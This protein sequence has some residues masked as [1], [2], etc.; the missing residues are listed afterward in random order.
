MLDCVGQV[1]G[2]RRCKP[3]LGEMQMRGWGLRLGAISRKVGAEGGS[4][5]ILGYFGV[6]DDGQVEVRR[7][8]CTYVL[9]AHGV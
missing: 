2:L 7:T 8:R 1:L 5:E 3:E 6:K 9:G 4:R